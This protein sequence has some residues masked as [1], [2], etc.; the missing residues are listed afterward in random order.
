MIKEINA[1]HILGINKN[2]SSWFG[3]KYIM[4][5]YRGCEHR[6]IYCDSRSKCYGIDNFDDVLVKVNAAELL[7]KELSGKRK[8]ATIGTGAMSDPYTF[9]EKKYKLTEKTLKIIADYGYPLHMTT[10]SNMVMRDIDILEEISKIYA[11]VA[12]TLTTTDDVL[13]R[14]V[15]PFAPIP[16][17]R[18]KAMGVLSVL[19]IDTGVTMMPI[20]PFIEDN[21]KN[22]I[23][24][25][26][27]TK[28]Y[29]GKFIYPTF[30]VTLR[31]VQRD[32]YYK[33]LDKKFPGLSQKYQKRFGE[34]YYCGANNYKKISETFKEACYK[35]GISTKMP[36]YENKLNSIQLSLFDKKE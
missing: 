9:S 7:K 4:N 21:E 36:S 1:K 28:E 3:I 30:G 5:I 35:Y 25:V 8:K 32:Y 2:P 20:L 10:K 31:D 27:Q 19:G 17:D 34:N 11:V 24:I 14:K 29:G 6:C 23:N 13:A 33:E 12:F 22:I 15:E 18:L 26:K 16:S